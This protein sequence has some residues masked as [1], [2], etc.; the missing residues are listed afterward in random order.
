[1]LN[2]ASLVGQMVV[3]SLLKMQDTKVWILGPEDSLEK[4]MV[5]PI[6]IFLPV[7]I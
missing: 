1:M 6:P 4:G 3:N 5:L 7:N 2:W